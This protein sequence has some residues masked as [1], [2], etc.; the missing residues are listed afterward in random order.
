MGAAVSYCTSEREVCTE[1]LFG[2]NRLIIVA[3]L[4]N[5]HKN[6]EGFV[7]AELIPNPFKCTWE[8]DLMTLTS[9]SSSRYSMILILHKIVLKAMGLKYKK[10]VRGSPL[11]CDAAAVVALPSALASTTST[12]LRGG[13]L[14][15]SHPWILNG[16]C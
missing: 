12:N 4:T 13:P 5:I 6:D 10:S 2:G 14:M 3:G 15:K 7:I 9:P 11:A 1:P 16:C 8:L